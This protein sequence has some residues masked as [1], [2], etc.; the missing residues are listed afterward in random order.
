MTM[1]I[2]AIRGATTLE[3]D[4]SDSM[5]SAV[6]E[7]LQEIF[8]ANSLKHEDLISIFFTS[9]PD[10]R[11]TFPATAARTLDLGDVP[12]MCAVEVDVP[13]ALPRTVRVMVHTHSER[14]LSEIKHIYLGGAV[15]LRKDIAQ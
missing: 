13:G 6:R 3:R 5:T 9:T 7:L 10:L 11:S 1:G 14:S 2:R 8:S 4:D 12:L 15:V